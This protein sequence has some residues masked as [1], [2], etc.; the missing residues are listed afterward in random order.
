MAVSNE[1][2]AYIAKAIAI[3]NKHPDPDSYVAEVIATLNPPEPAP[4]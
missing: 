1:D 3:A 4:E 2:L